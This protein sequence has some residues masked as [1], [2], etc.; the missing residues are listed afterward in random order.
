MT[1]TR[2]QQANQRNAQ[3]STGP[4][5]AAGKARASQ[6]A[7]RHGLTAQLPLLTS[8][9]Q[10][11]QIETMISRE[12]ADPLLARQLALDIFQFERVESHLQ[13]LHVETARRQHVVMEQLL[14]A[15]ARIWRAKEALESEYEADHLSAGWRREL[16]VQQSLARQLEQA[17]DKQHRREVEKM[18]NAHRQATRHF[19]RASNQLIKAGRAVGLWGSV[20][21]TNFLQNAPKT[22]D[23]SL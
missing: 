13:R 5:S 15:W 2:R 1:S 6:N 12:V 19:K 16:R 20:S 9:L 10:F 3:R 11:Q 7:I 8:D 22:I 23:P 21:E 18:I 14:V 17:L 4:R